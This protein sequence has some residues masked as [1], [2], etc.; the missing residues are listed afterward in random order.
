MIA[1]SLDTGTGN[2]ALRSD[3]FYLGSRRARRRGPD[4]DAFLDRYI[5]TVSALFPGALLHFGDFSPG[6]AR[7]IV[8]AYGGYRVFS[9]ELQG[10][11]TAVL[12]AVYAATRVT[13]IP[14]KHQ[15]PVV[16]GAGADGVS[17]RRPAAR[18]HDQRRCHR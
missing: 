11:G 3:P 6:T 7:K 15:E 4:C 9:D 2:E 12:A 5:Q 1:V 10:T 17:P 18:R 8:H 13:G 16:C 14:M